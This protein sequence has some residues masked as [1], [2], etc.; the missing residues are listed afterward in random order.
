MWRKDQDN[1]S[2]SRTVMP[3]SPL[4]HQ[5]KNMK[6][7][8]HMFSDGRY[9]IR[10]RPKSATCHIRYLPGLSMRLGVLNG[11]V[12]HPVLQTQRR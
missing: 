10:R 11:E 6:F 8:M 2:R 1:H 3:T 5:S 7:A 4:D 12:S 9:M